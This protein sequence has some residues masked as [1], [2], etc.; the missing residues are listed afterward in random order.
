M[1]EW[2][3]LWKNPPLYDYPDG[4]ISDVKIEGDRMQ[5]NMMQT[6]ELNEKQFQEIGRLQRENQQ[7]REDLELQQ[8]IKNQKLEAI[9]TKLR[10]LLDN[11]YFKFCESDIQEILDQ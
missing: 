11:G 3:K 1:T 4:W 8:A 5:E 9:Q 6:H 10:W 7:L 2:N